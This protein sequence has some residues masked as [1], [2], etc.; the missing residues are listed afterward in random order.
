MHAA[1]AVRYP[2]T[3]SYRVA[4]WLAGLCAL[5]L[6][7][8]SAWWAASPQSDA[9]HLVAFGCWGVATLWAFLTWRGA[10]VGHLGWDGQHWRWE[11]TPPM[12]VLPEGVARLHL[13]LQSQL[14][15]RFAPAQGRAVWL[16]LERRPARLAQW[17]LLRCALLCADGSGATPVEGPAVAR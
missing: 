9:L 3:R 12:A 4:A 7:V 15:V 8:L 10:L 1:P 14:L 2:V 6:A 13:D 5:E 11:S 17:H 16:W